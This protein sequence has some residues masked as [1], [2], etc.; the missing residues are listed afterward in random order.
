MKKP[1]LRVPNLCIHLQTADERAK[2]EINKETHLAP[3]FQM[4]NAEI[5]KDSKEVGGDAR[6]APELLSLIAAEIGC[7]PGQIKDMDV[8]RER[9]LTTTQCY[10][11]A[12][13]A[14]TMA[15]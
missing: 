4:I 3:I 11:V 14:V 1:I 5:N 8:S 2:L 13:V 10:G 6:H 15:L 7:T 12:C 9:T